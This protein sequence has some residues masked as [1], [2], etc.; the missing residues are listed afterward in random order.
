MSESS[1][2]RISGTGS[3]P[4]YVGDHSLS[5]E[6][7]WARLVGTDA[8]IDID[9]RSEF[10]YLSHSSTGSTYQMT[11]WHIWISQI[12]DTATTEMKNISITTDAGDIVLL[13][14]S[15]Q[16]YST[17][18]AIRGDITIRSTYSEYILKAGNRIMVSASDLSNPGLQMATLAGGIDESITQSPL[19]V[20][21]NGKS[22]LASTSMTGSTTSSSGIT[23]PMTGSGISSISILEPTPW[24]IVTT[25]T[26]TIRGT[27]TS[28]IKRITISNIDAV[29]SPVNGTFAYTGFPI[30]GETNDIVYKWYDERGQQVQVGVLTIFWSKQALQSTQKLLPNTSPLSSSDYRI[31]S[32]T[33]NPYVMTDRATKVQWT[34]PKDTVGSIMVNDYKLQKFIPGST[35]WYYFAN[36]ESGTMKDGINLYTIKFMWNKGELLYTQLFT[37][38][39]ESKN[40]TISGETSR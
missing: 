31:T 6:S 4:L 17:V 23:I 5:V 19:F 34:V 16:I 29:I 8:I 30:S 1:K 25:P 38:I 40:A 10:A 33:S 22:I 3:Q 32:P 35:T 9:E 28:D 39:K 14:Q 24:S 13:E 36:M 2:N 11:R 12:A 37:I 20:K 18:Y 15:N 21:N 26:T 7:G 27:I